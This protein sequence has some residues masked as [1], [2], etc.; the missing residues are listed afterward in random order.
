MN[1]VILVKAFFLEGLEKSEDLSTQKDDPW[2]ANPQKKESDNKSAKIHVEKKINS[3]KLAS[4]LELALAE[5]YEAGFSLKEVVTVTSGAYGYKY[6]E[7][8]ITS[9]AR[10]FTGTE[11]VNG[12]ASYGYGYGYSYTD[13]L[14]VIG[15]K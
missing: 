14:I 11:A 10:P 1:K 3:E 5:L 2:A 8:E 7:D 9:F 12:G 13:S 6:K 15:V 4:D